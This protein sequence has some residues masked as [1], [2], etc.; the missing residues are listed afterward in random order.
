MPSLPPPT[1]IRRY[2]LP[3]RLELKS[4][5]PWNKCFPGKCKKPQ[6]GGDGSFQSG[7]YG[8]KSSA[9]DS[10]PSDD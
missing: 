7:V 1:E 6:G 4:G 8:G 3:S 10:S 5:L 9:V 2:K